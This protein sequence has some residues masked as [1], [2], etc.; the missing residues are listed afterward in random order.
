MATNYRIGQI[1]EMTWESDAGDVQKGDLGTVLS[2]PYRFSI[3]ACIA[4][5]V[6]S[7]TFCVYAVN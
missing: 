7:C 1:V 6:A 5:L 3:D 4:E 2:T